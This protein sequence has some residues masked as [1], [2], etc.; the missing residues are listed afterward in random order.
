MKNVLILFG[1][2]II[3]AGAACKKSSSADTAS[4]S[5]LKFTKLMAADT[6]IKVNDATT[7]TAV[8][9]GD[10]LSYKWTASY[11]TFIGSGATVQWTVCHQ[12]KFS[13]NCEVTDKYNHA[14]TKNIVV[15][16]VN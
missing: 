3:L 12:D 4:G 16:S 9:S 10:G 7:I 6:V 8:A 2:F 15:R 14:E 5:T 11:G 13:I 1:I